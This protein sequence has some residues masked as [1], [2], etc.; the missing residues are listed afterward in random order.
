MNDRFLVLSLIFNSNNLF[1]VKVI[2]SGGY[3][4]Q[5]NKLDNTW[6][7][8]KKNNHSSHRNEQSNGD[9][10]KKVQ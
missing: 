6:C 3:D 9:K 8:L 4:S 5:K 2:S 1:C 10:T 7:I